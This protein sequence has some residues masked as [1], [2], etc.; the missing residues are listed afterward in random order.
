MV[1]SNIGSWMDEIKHTDNVRVATVLLSIVTLVA[2]VICLPLEAT[3]FSFETSE[4][5]CNL[6]GD[7]A[8]GTTSVCEPVGIWEVEPEDCCLDSRLVGDGL[9]N[10][11]CNVSSLHFDGGDCLVTPCEPPDGSVCP[12]GSLGNGVCDE[13][14]DIE[15]CHFDYGDCS[16]GRPLDDGDRGDHGRGHNDGG[17]DGNGGPGGSGGGGPGGDGNGGHGGHGGGGPGGHRRGMRQSVAVHHQESS[18]PGNVG[19]NSDDRILHP[20]H[21]DNDDMEGG[22]WCPSNYTATTSCCVSQ[23]L[24]TVCTWGWDTSMAGWVIGFLAIVFTII[25][26]VLS[27]MDCMAARKSRADQGLNDARANQTAIEL[28][29]LDQVAEPVVQIGRPIP[30]PLNTT[31]NKYMPTAEPAF[32]HLQPAV[33]AAPAPPNLIPQ[34]EA[35]ENTQIV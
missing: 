12:T 11:G 24:E 15:E 33:V 18:S 20:H 26:L 25:A 14:C 7:E 3:L 35:A 19:P 8:C 22:F 29:R 10:V 31:D 1:V 16:M 2:L 17:D 4:W 27:I 30:N 6:L 9:C 23:D 5:E 34:K 28:N 32:S 21:D 13:E